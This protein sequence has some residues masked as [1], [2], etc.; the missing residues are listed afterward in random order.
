MLI[1]IE[2]KSEGVVGDPFIYYKILL[3][4]VSWKRPAWNLT[5]PHLKVASSNGQDVFLL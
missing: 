1:L 3:E 4:N 5:F 2:R